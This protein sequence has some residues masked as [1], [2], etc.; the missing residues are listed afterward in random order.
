MT[1]EIRM[2]I[3]G[4]GVIAPSHAF[5]IDQAQGARLA[6]VCGRRLEPTAELADQYG[7]ESVTDIDALLDAVDAVTLCTPS[8][9]HADPAVAAAKALLQP[10]EGDDHCFHMPTASSGRAHEQ[11]TTGRFAA[12]LGL[13]PENAQYAAEVTGRVQ[14][15]HLLV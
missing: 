1:D 9:A 13:L 7:A 15:L 6:A 3:I 12:V 10:A 8:G 14:T 5:A 2:G 4:P 11:V